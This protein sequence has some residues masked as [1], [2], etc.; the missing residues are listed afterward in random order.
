MEVCLGEN[1]IVILEMEMICVEVGESSNKR[2]NGS[3]RGSFL[4]V[5]WV[6]IKW[7]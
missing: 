7:L 2:G 4:L 5:W 6:I 1:E 3:I